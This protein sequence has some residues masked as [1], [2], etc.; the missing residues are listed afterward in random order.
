MKQ[1]IRIITYNIDG[2]PES[3]DLSTVSFFLKPIAW[4]YKLIKKTTIIKINDNTNTDKHIKQ[5]SKCLLNAN[6]DIIGVQ[7]DFNYHN[8]LMESLSDSYNYSTHTG[9][10]DLTKLLS[11]IEIITR[12]P[13]PRFKCDGLNLITRK[14]NVCVVDEKIIRWK[15]S[16]GYF[17]HANDTL[18]HKGFRQYTMSAYGKFIDVYVIHMDA[19]FYS[20]LK[21]DTAPIDINARISQIKQLVN[22]IIGRYNDGIKRPIIIMGDTNSNVDFS[23]DK[24]NIQKNLLDAINNVEGLSI[25]EVVPNN[26]KDVD[27]IF[28]IN[29]DGAKN[30]IEKD[31]CYYDLSFNEEI[32]K[33]S[34]HWPLVANLYIKNKS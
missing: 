5:I 32:G 33:I 30:E 7:E 14:S 3:L 24:E 2:L 11:K 6:P 15:K 26:E 31:D 25:E 29:V 4:I 18:T 22:Y 28:I 21:G 13:L 1:A 12:F 19:D 17:K 27:R 16:C 23:W 20:D 34:D 10:I 9:K 8:E